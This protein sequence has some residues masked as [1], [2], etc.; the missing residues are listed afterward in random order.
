[1]FDLEYDSEY[2]NLPTVDSPSLDDTDVPLLYHV[3][4]VETAR[5]YVREVT[6]RDRS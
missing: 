3:D 1:M 4:D 5:A 2:D 6:H